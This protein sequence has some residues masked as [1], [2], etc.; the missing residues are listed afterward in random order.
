MRWIFA[1]FVLC[2]CTRTAPLPD[3]RAIDVAVIGPMPADAGPADAAPALPTIPKLTLVDG[4]ED[5]Y[6][7]KIVAEG[8]PAISPDGTRVAMMFDSPDGGRGY[9]ARD[10]V[11]LSVDKDR[12]EKR[13]KILVSDEFMGEATTLA[14]RVPPRVAA[15]QAELK[16]FVPMITTESE[17][18]GTVGRATYKPTAGVDVSLYEGKLTATKDEKK[19][20]D[21]DVK[22]WNV[23]HPP[24]TFDPWLETIAVD[25][26]RHVLA[27]FVSQ[28]EVGG[29][30][31]CNATGSA[32][33]FRLTD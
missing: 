5:P 11:I 20:L 9:P 21:R 14:T 12:I 31:R 33:A 25:A 13:V 8:I 7:W 4:G 16:D 18:N 22:R 2:A 32:H 24:C 30:D 29:G 17:W 3:A 19:L 27:V 6:N 28:M 10:L 23:S 26:K 15:A 1:G